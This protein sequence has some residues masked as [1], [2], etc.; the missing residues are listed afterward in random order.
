MVGNITIKL[1]NDKCRC[2]C[3]NLKEHH[4]FKKDYICSY[5]TYSCKNVNI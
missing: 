5:A 1:N 4:S 2:E 3:K